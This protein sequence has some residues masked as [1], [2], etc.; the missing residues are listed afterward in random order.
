MGNLLDHT[1]MYVRRSGEVILQANNQGV[2]ARDVSV[3][4]FLVI[5]ENA[6]FED[7]SSGTDQNRTACFYIGG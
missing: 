4:N 3:A 5:G 1:G 6:R 7:Y 2:A